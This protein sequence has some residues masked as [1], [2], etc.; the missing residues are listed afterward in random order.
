MTRTATDASDA[1]SKRAALLR[2]TILKRAFAGKLVPQDPS[3]VPAEKLL[4]RTR[5]RRMKESLGHGHTARRGRAN[6]LKSVEHTAEVTDPK[7]ESNRTH[8]KWPESGLF[9]D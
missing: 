7:A 1:E 4:E 8:K 3:D 5:E 2:Q 9:D 6:R